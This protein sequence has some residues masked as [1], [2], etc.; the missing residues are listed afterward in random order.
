VLTTGVR[1]AEGTPAEI[2]R[3]PKVIEAYLGTGYEREPHGLSWPTSRPTTA[4]SGRSR[5]VSLTV[6]Q[7][8]I[9]TLIG[10]NGAGKTTTLRTI[11][12]TARPRRRHGHLQRPAYRYARHRPHRAAGHRAV[13]EGRRIFRAD[14]AGKSRAWR[15]SCERTSSADRPRSRRVV[16]A[17]PAA[18]PSA[19]AQHGGRSRA[20]SSRCWRSAGADG[21]TTLLL[22]RRAV[23]GSG[24]DPGRTIFRIV[25][26]INRSGHDESCG[27][28]RTRGWRSGGASRLRFMQTGRIV[29]PGRGRRAL[30]VGSSA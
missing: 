9:V 3:H 26:D 8:E 2:Q 25:Q 7:G 21:A 6:A 20:A 22:A 4:T 28:S 29:L 19:V 30:A 27:P 18:W 14:R 12:G 1:I 5:G 23:D 10:S 13:A 24:S 11:L 17:L 15:L 16:R